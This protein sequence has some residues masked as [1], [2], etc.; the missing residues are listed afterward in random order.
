[1]HRSS[2]PKQSFSFSLFFFAYYGYVGVFSPYASLYFADKGMTAAEIGVLMSLM[3]VM[4]IFG[5]NLWGWVADRHQQRVG[6]LR[7]TA[8]AA[9][10]AFGGM[11]FGRSFT[12]LLVVMAAVNL[13]T[14]AQ[15]PL[16]EALML[17]EM[18]GDLT[19]YGRLRLWG[20]V[21]FIMTV[22]V[23]GPLLDR[24]GIRVMPWIALA[25]LVLVLASTVRMQETTHG[26][27]HQDM[28]S[29]LALLRRREVIAFFSST[30]LMIAAH[31]A[32]YVFYSLYLAQIGYNNTVIGLMWSLGVV[33]EIAFFFFQ[34]P[35]FRRFGIRKL[36]IASLLIAVVRFLLI[37]FGAQS[38][39]VLLL[40]QVLHAATFGVHH[41][42]SVATL[43]RWFSGPLQARGQA[44]YTSISYGLGGTL[45]GLVLGG[46]W[47]TFGSQTVY[48]MAAMF[49]LA[50][51]GA[52]TLSYRWQSHHREEKHE[53]D[54][55]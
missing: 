2:W 39:A 12:Q 13:F 53:A 45:G 54:R 19:H 31:A 38:L 23:A 33:V 40:A 44:L 3:Q 11:F 50:G 5:P 15:G 29:V 16:S 26:D 34:A 4:R 42:A 9:V 20:S 10:A 28:P 1:M 8:I 52:A 27:L 21:G 14:S 7:I 18:R 47:D 17:S 43:Q 55:Q 36:M 37:G 30:F 32:L 49:A 24:Y 41:S 48:L 25:L 46:L 51:A 22:A 6:V 35:I